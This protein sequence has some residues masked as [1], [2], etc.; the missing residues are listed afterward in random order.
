MAKAHCIRVTPE[1]VH[2][3][4]QALGISD[5]KAHANIMR[6]AGDKMVDRLPTTDELKEFIQ[7]SVSSEEFSGSTDVTYQDITPSETTLH[8][9]GATGADYYWAKAGEKYGIK[10]P[11]HYYHPNMKSPYG[12]TVI[13]NED[14]EEGR[15]KAA[16]AAE[17]NYGYQY[18]TMKDPNLIRDWAQV[19]HADAVFAV[20]VFSA[21]G[22]RLFPNKKDDTRVAKNIA[23]Q[24]GTGYAVTMAVLHKKPVYV[25]DQART[26]WYTYNYSTNKW[27]I[28]NTPTLTRNFAGIGTRGLNQVGMKAIDEVYEKTFRQEGLT[29]EQVLQIKTSNPVLTEIITD[30]LKTTSRAKIKAEGPQEQS[31]LKSVKVGDKVSVV[32]VLSMVAN[33]ATASEGNKALAAAL[34]PLFKD[35]GFEVEFVDEGKNA[36]AGYVTSNGTKIKHIRINLGSSK[37]QNYASHTILHELV[38][39]LSISRLVVDKEFSDEVTY[40]MN[41]VKEFLK[42]KGV[43]N[44]T[45]YVVK[46]REYILPFDIYGLTNPN[47]FFAEA[48]SD[49]N[50]QKLLASIPAYEVNKKRG[51]I[52]SEIVNAICNAFNKLFNQKYD[53]NLSVF[54]ALVPLIA[55]TLVVTADKKLTND[56]ILSDRNW[57]RER[58]Q[59]QIDAAAQVIKALNRAYDTAV[60]KATIAPYKEFPY[61]EFVKLP[62]EEQQKLKDDFISAANK[63]AASLGLEFDVEDLSKNR[64]GYRFN[65]GKSKI[66]E[67]SF[68]FGFR[69]A[70][71]DQ[72]RMFSNLIGDLGYQQQETVITA[73]DTAD[74][75]NADGQRYTIKIKDSAD[76]VKTLNELNIDNFTVD[77]TRGTLTLLS[78]DAEDVAKIVDLIKK[79][80]DNGNHEQTTEGRDFDT[81][82][83]KSEADGKDTRR[84]LYKEWLDLH[85]DETSELHNFVRQALE[86]HE[87]TKKRTI[88]SKNGEIVLTEEQ[89]KA[90]DKVTKF[91]EEQANSGRNSTGKRYITISG[92]AG[93]GKTTIIESIIKQLRKDGFY[94]D[95]AGAAVSRKAVHVLTDKLK[96]YDVEKETVYTLSGANPNQSEDQFAIDPNKQKFSKYGLIFIDEASMIGQKILDA[97][98][99]YMQRNPHVVVVF[100]GDYGQV[101][102]ISTGPTLEG[103]SITIEGQ[104]TAQVS[105]GNGKSA[106][107][108]PEKCEIVT[109]TERI[110]QGEGSPILSYADKFYEISIGKSTADLSTITRDQKVTSINDGGGIIFNK[111]STQ[112]MLPKIVEIFRRAADTQNPT[113]TKIVTST[114]AKVDRFNNAVHNQLF[115]NNPNEIVKGD[116]IIFNAPYSISR[117]ESIDNSEEGVVLENLG[118]YEQDGVKYITYSI[119]VTDGR[120]FTVNVLDKNTPGN[121]QAF[122]R[123]CDELKQEALRLNNSTDRRARAEAWTAYYSYLQS[124]ADI[125]FGYAMTIHK[126]QGSTYDMIFVDEDGIRTDGQWGN[127]ERA[128]ILY[129][130]L[131][132]GRNL[133]IVM[134]DVNSGEEIP[135]YL[136]LNDKIEENKKQSTADS[137][138]EQPVEEPVDDSVDLEEADRLARERRL[139]QPQQRQQSPQLRR[140]LEQTAEPIKPVDKNDVSR[141]NASYPNPTTK[142]FRVQQI[143]VKFSE[144]LEKKYQDR[145]QELREQ[146]AEAEKAGNTELAANLYA[147][148]IGLTKSSY[149]NEI[150]GVRSLFEEIY[151][152]YDPE[153]VTSEA[154]RQLFLENYGEQEG[155]TEEDYQDEANERAEYKKKEYAKV[156][157][158]FWA[159]AEEATLDIRKR[160]RI[161][162]DVSSAVIRN[163][164]QSG[165]L[166]DDN[167][168]SE[169]PTNNTQDQEEKSPESWMNSFRSISAI[170]SLSEK[171]R[172][173][174]DRLYET[175]KEG[176]QEFTDLG[177][178]RYL[179]AE[180]AH[181]VLLYGLA[182]MVSS[183]DFIEDILELGKKYSFVR[184]LYSLDKEGNPVGILAEDPQLMAAFYQ[185]F[186]K[187]ITSYWAS[188]GNRDFVSKDFVSDN[189]FP[190]NSRENIGYLLASWQHNIE[191]GL[192]I[193]GKLSIFNENGTLNEKVIGITDEDGKSPKGTISDKL[194]DL[195]NKFKEINNSRLS[196]PDRNSAIIHYLDEEGGWSKFMEILR[197]IGIDQEE[198]DIRWV[199]VESKSDSGNPI[200][201]SDVINN[202]HVIIGKISD[203]KNYNKFFSLDKEG[204]A[205]VVNIL[206][207]FKSAYTNIAQQISFLVQGESESSFH[208]LDKTRYSYTTPNYLGKTMKQL[209][210]VRGDEKFDEYIET[211]F[212]QFKWFKEDGVWLNSWIGDLV[213][214]Q[215]L[216]KHFKHKVVLDFNKKGFFDIDSREY[217]LGILREFNGAKSVKI[218]G[219]GD[220][221]M[222]W[223]YVPMLSDTD[224]S[225]FIQFTKDTKTGYQERLIDKMRLTVYQ[226]WNRIK[227]VRKRQQKIANGEAKPIANFD[228]RGDS[229]CFF[230]ALNDY[231][232]GNNVSFAD[233]LDEYDKRSEEADKNHDTTT[234]NTVAIERAE[235]INR[236]LS[237]IIEQDV[238]DTYN[239]Y[240]R[241]GVFDKNEKTGKYK[242]LAGAK[243]F[244]GRDAIIENSKAFI[245]K[246]LEV[247]RQDPDRYPSF[248]KLAERY[249]SDP[250]SVKL[251]SRNAMFDLASTFL[252]QQF[253]FSDPHRE[254]VSK[255]VYNSRF[256][257]SQIEQIFATD[258]AYYKDAVDFQKRF[259]EIHAPALRLYTNAEFNGKLIGRKTERSI[260]LA[261][262]KIISNTY[263]DLKE[264][265]DERVRTGQLSEA[266]AAYIL[267]QYQKINV[268]DAQAYRCLS[269]YRAVL[270]M[271]GQWDDALEGAYKRLTSGKWG[272]EDFS[273]IFQTKKPYLYTQTGIDSQVENEGMIK[274][275][276]QHKNSEFLLLAMLPIMVAGTSVANKVHSNKLIALNEFMEKGYKEG[277]GIDVVNFTSAVKVGNQGVINFTYANLTGKPIKY[278]GKTYSKVKD[279]IEDLN[280]AFSSGTISKER[281]DEILAPYR[282]NDQS[283]D[284]ILEYLESKTTVNGADNPQFIHE[285]DYEDYGIQTQTPE[286]II[287]HE[288][289]FGTQIRRLIGADITPGTILKVGGKKYTAEKW[290]EIYNGLLIDNIVQSYGEVS[291]KFSSPEK[292][293]QTLID[294]I[295]S[296]D[297]YPKD[298]LNAIRLVD[299]IGFDGKPTGN[300]RFNIPLFDNGIAD[301]VES[302]IN[303]VIKD[304]ITKQKIKGGSCIQVSSFGFSDKL[305]VVYEGKGENKRVK[306]LECYMP[307]YSK[308]FYEGLLIAVDSE[309]NEIKE[310]SGKEIAGYTLDVNK[311]PEELRYAIGYR[312]PTEDKY[313]MAPL[314]IKGFLPQQNGSAIM[315]PA[316]ITTLSGSDFDVDKMYI[317]LPE[318]DV[319]KYDKERAKKDY[320]EY[321]RKLGKTFNWIDNFVDALLTDELDEEGLTDEELEEF[322]S[323]GADKRRVVKKD[324]E[325][326]KAFAEWWK[327][328]KENYK[329]D[330]PTYRKIKGTFDDSGFSDGLEKKSNPSKADL[331][332][333]RKKR[334]NAI[335]DMMF[336][337]LTNAD[338]L[339]RFVKPGGY[340]E[341]KKQA[342]IQRI[343]SNISYDK[344]ETILRA[345]KD[346]KFKGS[347]SET[348]NSLNEDK[349]A[350]LASDYGKVLD[351]LSVTTQLHFHKQNAA[352]SKAIGI[353]AVNN[354]GQALLQHADEKLKLSSNKDSNEGINIFGKKKDSLREV[355]ND[356]GQYI[357]NNEAQYLAAAVDNGKDPT[358]E[359]NGQNDFTYNMSNLLIRL[360]YTHAEVS[361]IMNQPII[362][363]MA[364]TVTKQIADGVSRDEAV[365]SVLRKYANKASVSGGSSNDS[366]ILMENITLED[367]YKDRCKGAELNDGFYARQYA[368]G[369]WFKGNTDNAQFLNNCT[370]NLRGDAQNAAAGPSVMSTIVREIRI[371]NSVKSEYGLYDGV[372]EMSI[373]EMK[374]HPLG[375]IIAFQQFGI[376][377]TSDI[378]AEYF[379]QYSY[380][381]M[382]T[383]SDFIHRTKN[384][385]ISVELAQKM[386]DSAILY[387]MSKLPILNQIMKDGKWET[388]TKE[389][390]IK[391]FYYTFPNEFKALKE[392]NDVLYVDENGREIRFNDVPIIQVLKYAAP[393]NS[394]PIAS[395]VMDN[396]GK[397]TKEGKQRLTQSWESLVYS[398]DDDARTL[399]INLFTYG[400]LRYAGGFSPNGYAHLSPMTVKES[401][402]GYVDTLENIRV[403][404]THI[405]G[406][407]EFKIL[408]M[409]NNTHER[410]LFPKLSSTEANNVKDIY[411]NED[412]KN[413]DGSYSVTAAVGDDEKCP[414]IVKV[415]VGDNKV[416]A[417]FNNGFCVVDDQNVPHFY[418]VLQNDNEVN[419]TI[420]EV[421]PLG[422]KDK[423]V[424]YIFDNNNPMSK[425]LIEEDENHKK[426]NEGDYVPEE[427]SVP[428]DLS[429]EGEYFPSS[430]TDDEENPICHGGFK[431]K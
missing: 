320:R 31:I 368:V 213:E 194:S 324:Y 312:V 206:Q 350:K 371:E 248:I 135:S 341:V 321:C 218:N 336:S 337:V 187:D 134:S 174:L 57:K 411:L 318:F 157:Q 145:L 114:N 25:F 146:R 95:I 356:K 140:V 415:H 190:L 87:P 382:S 428:S 271:S 5:I 39:S 429:D 304:T 74:D 208:H 360:G 366:G 329:L 164:E 349:L 144:L 424:E 384:R 176:W 388:A 169:N 17:Y 14:I 302:L 276:V 101:R 117:N 60:I 403:T 229:F 306:Y 132:R 173:V 408:F 376:K 343:L 83:I 112:G 257:T 42:D 204:R 153:S 91:I 44:E 370:Q 389:E 118:V 154:E 201:I 422:V 75:D 179:D 98:D 333:A 378:L 394:N 168:G 219:I 369:L 322:T 147:K 89:Q 123:K 351:P 73:M 225:E 22:E 339:A 294:V 386:F 97:I 181:A 413:S 352:G 207:E 313:S 155:W 185:D 406:S 332:R 203:K 396:A 107:F 287:D 210:G 50:F 367:M 165:Y 53:E 247:A 69:N 129:T 85:K 188:R 16:R 426:E 309:G 216:R 113:I 11:K 237:E 65:D 275:G 121:E 93:T 254:M 354:A 421:T 338:T 131:T 63:I 81:V 328:N 37:I 56:E 280:K 399:A 8:S 184:Q 88:A 76:A 355:V 82:S 265:L 266:S 2:S 331:A 250:L 124:F 197:S 138:Q 290:W 380:D 410:T 425:S 334:N 120:V 160:D 84:A 359:D 58:T 125:S 365:D 127:Q 110:R 383:L 47:E 72:V 143:A 263:N 416:T 162:I 362:R 261:D 414:S 297:R 335:I 141:L 357:T 28:C 227:L 137:V 221:E 282:L 327:K 175:D 270:G 252:G 319:I 67:L 180:Y 387:S 66:V 21:V 38:H 20:G 30:S 139:T 412:S 315:L 316:E 431:L 240:V 398:G 99:G 211:Q 262:E 358:L 255:L 303:S 19:K 226:E 278:A 245:T 15:Y 90:V 23:V 347:V 259:K 18:R 182:N 346:I 29:K 136:A 260:Y 151:N 80:K 152:Q 348:L 379:P 10:E 48:F 96:K 167:S 205:P 78:F 402:S 54:S 268:S 122:K 289:L 163:D 161:I 119:K 325:D 102:P 236:V 230:P 68:T 233:R 4:A 215:D 239:Q 243:D 330:R 374:A 246:A 363:E 298:L 32:D 59:E 284:K 342:Y 286:H 296:S 128:E 310:G 308:K 178:N 391:Y 220:Q 228:D 149:L 9:G 274:M 40:L 7:R 291:E 390:V 27:E 36:A 150:G 235:F 198:E 70:T 417:V 223:Y 311:L 264:A 244:I 104:I 292:L 108:N 195:T 234:L 217:A 377:Q 55:D 171:T 397:L 283:P 353:Y 214:H 299:E 34:I 267:K 41:R 166:N 361:A 105:N 61:E 209:Q 344:L 33:E 133:A 395:I 13:D 193:G 159:L 231:K 232:D 196:V 295:K 238:E 323:E 86:K 326:K 45:K 192:K 1:E 172:R 393:S 258:L 3:L 256:A 407:E 372:S 423:M 301:V 148:E 79:L 6:W 340:V 71:F 430:Y 106:V 277:K 46:G 293:Q 51:N 200:S 364:E 314:Y 392:K 273:I 49:E 199:L 385:S 409:R 103:G 242:Y 186:R 170:S 281:Y 52:L 24:G 158:N 64:G 92:Q 224:S 401:V 126:A 26:E 373:A 375:F 109:L 405:F 400:L 183:D 420:V 100:L 111:Y 269:S 77:E 156:Q 288:Q 307:A 189:T 142:K 345:S 418:V 427:P 251:K 12:N 130:A 241:L 35:T 253:S 222:A 191:S 300:K 272:I 249:I 202:L 305:S 285:L 419:A 62:K 115:P 279:L 404:G 177:E 94:G 116:M 212:G 43:P 317:M 381:F